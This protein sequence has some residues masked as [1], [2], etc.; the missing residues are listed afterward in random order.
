M[1]KI[2]LGPSFLT[3]HADL[4]ISYIVRS[5]F[6]ILSTLSDGKQATRISVITALFFFIVTAQPPAEGEL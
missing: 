4:D 5:I 1:I 3:N 6:A 2:D